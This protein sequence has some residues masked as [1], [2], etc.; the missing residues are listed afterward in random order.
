MNMETHLHPLRTYRERHGI[1][2]AKLAEIVGTT[3]QSLFRIEGGTQRPALDMMARIAAA[4]NGEVT[5]NDL[6][7]AGQNSASP[8]AA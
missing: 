2:L 8:E 1:S 5:A 3:R 4:T 7:A 6:V